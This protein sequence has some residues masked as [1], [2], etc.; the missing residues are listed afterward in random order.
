MKKDYVPA[1]GSTS[2]ETDFVEE[3]WT[4]V[5]EKEGGPQGKLEK[6]PKTNEY[7]VIKPFLDTLPAGAKLLDGGCGL[8]DWVLYFAS[9]GYSVVGLDLSKSTVAL[10]N[11]KFPGSSFSDGDI[12]KMEY[13]DNTFDAYYSWGVFE[14]FENGMQECMREAYRVLKPGGILF[15]SVPLDNLRHALRGVFGQQTPEK[16]NRRFYQWRFTKGELA[17]ELNIGGFEVV[18]ISPIHKRQGVLRSLH[19][20]FGMP[21][22]W[23]LTKALSVLI[24]PFVPGIFISHMVLAVARKP[25][26]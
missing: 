11:E 9:K 22:S 17:Q 25:N 24:A 21:Y 8:G 1:T 18:K 19:H 14:H 23:F 26:E 2:S 6:I 13:E 15:I 12:R 16:E 20:E 3:Y 10:L 4:K 5:W 7:R